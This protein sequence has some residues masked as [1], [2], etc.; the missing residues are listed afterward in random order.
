MFLTRAKI[1][2][3]NYITVVRHF[4]DPPLPSC[5]RD[6]GRM[7]GKVKP[8]ESSSGKTKIKSIKTSDPFIFEVSDVC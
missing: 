3:D 4:L 6:F 7:K 1:I 5:A 2:G 8:A